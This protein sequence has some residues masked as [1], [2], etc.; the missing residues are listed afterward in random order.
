VLLLQVLAVPSDDG[1]VRCCNTRTGEVI[2]E[3]IGHEDAVQ[4]TVFDPSGQFLATC[5]SDN[6]FKLWN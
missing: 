3:L 5:S 4:G 6:T 1:K 2:C